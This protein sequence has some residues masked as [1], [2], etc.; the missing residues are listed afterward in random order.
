MDN[1]VFAAL[2]VAFVKATGWIKPVWN[3]FK[4]WC[5]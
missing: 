3:R 2:V 4:M 5:G 1:P